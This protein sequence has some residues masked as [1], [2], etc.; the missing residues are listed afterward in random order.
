MPGGG[1]QG[2]ILGMFL[3]LVLINDAGFKKESESIGI[4]LTKAFNKRRE[5]DTKHWKYVDDLT[6]AEALKLKESLENDDD[7]IL[8]KPLT[9]HNRTNQILPQEASQVQKQLE[10]IHE[11]AVTNE[12][13]VNHKKSKVMLFNTSQKYD[14]TPAL[15]INNDKLE[16]VEE[17]KLL[18]VKITNDLKWEQN[19]KYITTKAYSRLWMLRRLKSLG[20]NNSE[21][22]DCFVKQ[23]RSVLE[24]CAVVWHPGLTQTNIVDIE[25]VQK[26]AC[27]IILGKQY[28]SY[29]DALVS[30]G[31]ERLDVRREAL[32][33]K[34]AKKAFK[35]NKY[36]SW[37]VKDV[38]QSNT[39]RQIKTVKEA[40]CRTK[41]LQ[42]SAL[43]YLTHILNI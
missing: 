7:D 15:A 10:E 13:K 43:P 21:L 34:F 42:K 32:S 17:L 33:R 38:N 3:F 14:F 19:T 9:Y 6:V 2:P 26:A 11:Y 40:Q 18:G 30:L 8:E 28:T 23:A 36:S 16:V 22:V 27:A 4:K 37:F 31:L 41:R 12:M 5:L 39:R 25:R 35:S 20:A 29:H 1:P 24:Y